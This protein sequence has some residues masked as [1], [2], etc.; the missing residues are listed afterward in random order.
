MKLCLVTSFRVLQ[1]RDP[2]KS[3]VLYLSYLLSSARNM[4]ATSAPPEILDQIFSKLSPA[5]LRNI[6]LVC[7]SF[8]LSS[9]RHLFRK[10]LVRPKQE[11][12]QNFHNIT[13]HPALRQYV[14]SLVYKVYRE[15]VFP[16]YKDFHEW[17]LELD[18]SSKTL[19]SLEDYYQAYVVHIEYEKGIRANGI[20]RS[21]VTEALAMLPNLTKVYVNPD[22]R[23]RMGKGS[24]LREC[25]PCHMRRNSHDSSGSESIGSRCDVLDSLRDSRSQI[26]LLEGPGL[27]CQNVSNPSQR[28][29]YFD[30]QL[31]HLA[32]KVFSYKDHP[33]VGLVE[34][35]QILEKAL[36]LEVLR[37]SFDLTEAYTPTALFDE[38]WPRVIHYSN[39]KRLELGCLVVSQLRL[40]SFLSL[41]APTLRSLELSEMEF[42]WE[43]ARDN[44]CQGSWTDTIHFLEERLNLTRVNF[45]G[46]LTNGWDEEWY[47]EARDDRSIYP[48]LYEDRPLTETLKYRIEQYVTKGG[49]CPLD[50]P[51]G[52]EYKRKIDY[53]REIADYSCT[54]GVADGYHADGYHPFPFDDE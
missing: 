28:L 6:R 53:W 25:E 13:S 24:V 50:L 27:A 44:N 12:L 45:V 1:Q 38:I 41:Q 2:S 26:K 17:F 15:C 3:D 47:F 7:Q 37:L 49:I 20:F 9:A 10:V 21:K 33:V 31:Q 5:D 19:E 51:R 39:L 40:M 30:R 36:K 46:L 22:V 42:E 14:R 43:E 4:M 11:C 23:Y 35:R 8:A 54:W 16:L 32:L 29:Q 18:P 52:R 48:F 34:L